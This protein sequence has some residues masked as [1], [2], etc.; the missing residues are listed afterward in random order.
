MRKVL[1]VLGVGV[2]SFPLLFVIWLLLAVRLP[3]MDALTMQMPMSVRSIVANA[4]AGEMG[5][6]KGAKPKL[7]RVIRI[8]PQNAS[9]WTG[10]CESYFGGP[11]RSAD[12]QTCQKAV[13]LDPTAGNYNGLGVAQE[14]AGDNCAAEDAYTEA[15]SKASSSG[16]YGY[17]ERMGRAA[18]LCGK[19]YDAR[20]GF[21]AA[22]DVEKRQLAAPDADDDEDEVA[23]EKQD[24]L[25]DR[26]Y[27]IVTANR[28]SDRKLAET[29]CSEAHPGWKGC[30][31]SLDAKGKVACAE[32]VR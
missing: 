27:L 21:E 28:L 4:A 9:A 2:L 12:V 29:T 19:A 8:D 14:R 7:E 1:V 5:W 10:L 6:G 17:T 15:A 24:L 30:A 18:L 26:E 25:T 11:E 20:A 23:D 3:K 31:C 16:S 13:T 22:I 32:A